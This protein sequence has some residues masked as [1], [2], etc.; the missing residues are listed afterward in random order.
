MFVTQDAFKSPLSGMFG[1]PGQHH[2]LAAELALAQHWFMAQVVQRPFPKE[3]DPHELD[4]T[5]FLSRLADLTILAHPD[6]TGTT[7]LASAF[8]VM[9]AYAKGG[10]DWRMERLRAVWTAN[11]P[12]STE[13]VEET[14]E[15]FETES[16]AVYNF[17]LHK[18]PVEKLL[19]R[20]LACQFPIPKK[21]KKT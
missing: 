4:R 15:I 16:G 13:E 3:K 7:R 17:S 11:E 12:D 20:V 14:A 6:P 10:M 21:G 9:P 1:E 8:I 18:T 19:N 2:W 5:L